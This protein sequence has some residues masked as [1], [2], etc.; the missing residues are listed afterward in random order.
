[1][2]IALVCPYAWDRVGGVQSHIRS[3]AVVLRSRGH[4]VIV[5]APR[6]S[7]EPLDDDGVVTAGRAVG[8]PANGSIA[9]VA[10][11]PKAAAGVER[12]LRDFDPEVVHLHEPLVPSLSLLALSR[13]DAPT[14]GTFHAAADGSLGYRAG[15]PV[16][17]R[18]VE[19]LAVRTVVSDAARA[20][21]QAYFPGEYVLTPNGVDCDRFARAEAEPDVRRVL[22]LSRIERRKG[23]EVLIRACA[24]IDEPR[25]QLVVAGTGPEEDACRNL[26]AALRVD[27][28]FIGR[29][30]EDRLSSV[31]ASA[32]VY[33][34]PALGG[35]SFGIVLLEA[36]AAGCAVVCSDLP[37]FRAV[38]GSAARLVPPGDA[39]ALAR[40]LTDVM[41]TPA[42]RAEMRRD[43]RAAARSYDWRR[44]VGRI[45][46]LYE[47]AAAGSHR[48]GRGGAR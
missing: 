17:Q 40:T 32:G 42:L 35:E 38:A 25:P 8:V 4:D 3:L 48:A 9:P 7:R 44:L 46:D 26:A 37:G 23:L 34:A 15:R 30:P 1:L 2:R 27:A 11:G 19:R 13:T 20:L 14:V 39:A 12:A 10:F 31:Y 36:M 41:T 43:S 45:E 47:M 18:A 6:S 16:L 22:F 33:C 28:R 24:L 21:V 29:V 5:I